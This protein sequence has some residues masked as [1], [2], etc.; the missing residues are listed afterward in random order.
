[1]IDAAGAQRSDVSP[2]T[3]GLL[4]PVPTPLTSFVGRDEELA[5]VR[6]SLARTRLLTH[7]HA[8]CAR[9][10]RDSGVCRGATSPGLTAG[11]RR[12]LAPLDVGVPTSSGR[13]AK[14]SHRRA[15]RTQ[16]V[17]LM[18]RAEPEACKRSLPAARRDGKAREQPPTYRFLHAN[19][20]RRPSKGSP[21]I[22]VVHVS[23]ATTGWASVITPV[24]T[25]SPA[26]SGGAC[27]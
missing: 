2:P 15:L 1:L 12:K 20:I 14:R 5:D 23:P 17:S 8:L 25:I 9:R 27:G 6:Q 7:G 13:T 26:R 21:R 18:S 4:P 16:G 11:W 3:D 19:V 22:S 24:V 10:S